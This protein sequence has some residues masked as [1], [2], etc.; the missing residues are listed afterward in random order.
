M[1]GGVRTGQQRAAGREQALAQRGLEGVQVDLLGD[2][3]LPACSLIQ[4]IRL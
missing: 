4:L 2:Q 1:R 3:R